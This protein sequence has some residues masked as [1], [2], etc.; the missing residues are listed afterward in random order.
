MTDFYR[1]LATFLPQKR[2][3]DNFLSTY[4]F[5]KHHK[6]FP[7][8]NAG[9]F[10]DALHYIRTTDEILNPLRGY[11]SDK[12]FIKDYVKAKIG[13]E[14]TIPTLAILNERQAQNFNYPQRA[15]IKP[16]HMSGEAL[17]RFKGE[18]LD[19]S[20]IQRWF[21]SNY[22]H[23]WREINYR[24]LEPKVIVEPLIFDQENSSNYT[25]PLDYKI[26]CL[27]GEPKII[28]V[29]A[30]RFKKHTRNFYTLDWE[31]LPI[32]FCHP[33][34]PSQGKPTNLSEILWIASIL[35][36]E[37]NLIR[38]DLYSDGKKIFVGEMTNLHGNGLEKFRSADEEKLFADY[39]FGPDGFNAK[40]WTK[41]K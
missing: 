19:S 5:W 38:I 22:Y 16:T 3:A 33:R 9:F 31:E 27:H 7:R 13:E 17:F 41:T 34:G 15:I 21:H 1:T 14:Y 30:G 6:R 2:W 35:S 40:T 24:Y 28:Q 8:K 25:I 23:T 37:F 4:N 36:K 12:A 29:D 32:E 39:L 18:T 20:K 10:N 11:I 26:F